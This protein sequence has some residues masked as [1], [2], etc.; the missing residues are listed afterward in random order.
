[1]Q[2]RFFYLL[3]LIALILCSPTLGSAEPP[4]DY[5]KVPDSV[6]QKR[7]NHLPLLVG[8]FERVNSIVRSGNEVSVFVRLHAPES[9]VQPLLGL[10]NHE[11]DK[12][13]HLRKAF[14]RLME[15]LPARAQKTATD[16]LGFI[17][18]VHMEI[19]AEAFDLLL[20]SPE[21]SLIEESQENEPFLSQSLPIIGADTDFTFNGNAG[22]GQTVAVLDTGFDLDHPFLQEK[23]AEEGCYSGSGSGASTLCP[24]GQHT[25]IGPGSAINCNHLQ[26]CAHGT[27]V[28][29]IA[30]GSGASF[31]G[32]ARDA[33]L[34]AIQV[35]SQKTCTDNGTS[36]PCLTA[37]DSDIVSGLNR[38]YDLRTAYQISSVNLS[39]GRGSYANSCDY[40]ST[41]F[42]AAIDRLK[43]SNIAT[44]AASGNDSSATG[45]SFPGCISSAISV[46]STTK[47]DAIAS[48]SNSAGIL[49]LLAPGSSIYSSVPAG[50][51]T[52]GYMYGTSMAAP[53]ATGAWAILRS[54]MPAAT[55]EN[56]LAALQGAGLPIYDSRNGF[57]KPRIQVDEAVNWLSSAIEFEAAE[58][59]VNEGSGQIIA[60]VKRT[61]NYTGSADISWSTS[62][63]TA[64][65]GSD[66]LGANGTIS[67]GQ[68]DMG[69][70]TIMVS[71]VN[72]SLPEPEEAFSLLLSSPTMGAVLGST[73]VATVKIANNDL[74]SVSGTVSHKGN[75]LVGVSFSVSAG[76][77]CSQSD[78]DGSYSCQVPYGWTGE[79]APA[80]G[81]YTFNPTNQRL[82]NVTIDQFGVDF[83]SLT[84]Q[85]AVNLNA[86]LVAILHLLL[87]N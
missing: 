63:G 1:M 51:G 26:S 41:A 14:N 85:E 52:W 33:N 27:H 60:K 54:K 79:I 5:F 64:E 39:L 17:P 2:Q 70:K 7:P 3:I 56:V 69:P 23:F 57:T 86:T 34:V 35:F 81:G 55:N 67:F 9:G 74:L 10:S 77:T 32:V 12:W 58:Y 61:G 31:S 45:I 42:K 6:L 48:Y 71:I 21:V 40:V 82:S 76:G 16:Y 20:S 50:F 68:G 18:Y 44:I 65:V 11:D 87:L 66:F 72:D 25:Q 73:S 36:Y 24:N 59:L 78:A 4:Q 15:T 37:Y 29:G 46:G 38:V 80:L 22:Q 84:D 53:H 13:A 28:A 43:T 30:S 19:D 47:S 75:P 83:T 62:S 49:D 8:N